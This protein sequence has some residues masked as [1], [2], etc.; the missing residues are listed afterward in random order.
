MKSRQIGVTTA[1]ISSS[2]KRAILMQHRHLISRVA[3]GLITFFAFVYPSLGLAATY[4]VDAATGND[5]LTSQQ[6]RDNPSA[7]LKTIKAALAFAFA[8]DTV[9]V[10]PGTYAEAVESKRDGAAGAL[11]TLQGTS[12]AVIQPPTKRNG[13]FVSHSYIAIKG[14]TVQ[15]AAT[16]LKLG[17][18]DGGSG[19]VAGLVI[20]NNTITNNTYGVKFTNAPAGEAAGNT[21]AQN[22]VDGLTFSNANN[23]NLHDNTVTR[24]GRFGFYIKGGTGHLLCNNTVTGNTRKDIQLTGQTI[25][26]GGGGGS[27]G[28]GGGFTFYVN[29]I[30]GDN[31]DATTS[32]K[33]ENGK[34]PNTPLKTINYALDRCVNPGDTV[35]LVAGTYSESVRTKRDGTANNPITITPKTPTDVVT[36]Q[37]PPSSPGIFVTNSYYIIDSLKITGGT[38]GV[39]VEPTATGV[40]TITGVTVRENEI[41]GSSI[42]MRFTNVSNIK[43]QA[44]VIHN[45]LANGIVYSGSAANIF[46]NLI[47]SNS[48]YGITLRAG[49]NHQITNN[50]V[51]N[52]VGG[53]RLGDSDT[54]PVFSTVLNNIVALNSSVGVKEPGGAN[55]AGKATLDYN[56]V[57]GN[58]TDYDLSHGAGGNTPGV[59]S[60]KADPVFV[61]AP[62]CANGH[63]FCLG[64]TQTGQGSDSPAIDKGSNTAESL[65]LGGS[66]AF[67]DM[68]P[69]A[70]QVD[71]GYHAP[72]KTTA[73]TLTITSATLTLGPTSQIFNVKA[74]LA[75]GPGSD[76]IQP[77]TQ[78]AKLTIG[79]Q[80]Y[81]LW[82]GGGSSGSVSGTLNPGVNGSVD[83]NITVNGLALQATVSLSTDI[84]I[85]VG[86][87]FGSKSII[88]K[89][90][91][92][93]P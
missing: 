90:T 22:T 75:P 38:F 2:Q 92:V 1:P 27:G 28:G 91:L 93:Y 17:P 24:N 9:S 10:Q 25:P 31:G 60:F 35:S 6:A 61:N 15:K 85:Q 41:S 23:A 73:G 72:L 77:S 74:N 55:Y 34:N 89:G 18:H 8:G 12:G 80:P 16:G 48:N 66:T 14:L 63:G 21:I 47:Y 58:S 65:S 84:G 7:P 83:V 57:F 51:A 5:S 37:P 26:C 52:N 45:C 71:L 49:S 81:Y 88:M 13:I 79:G 87:D 70:G 82:P 62:L 39:Q 29:P 42:G 68:S 67:V 86:D 46:N 30:T 4:Y 53:L 44:N 76:G 33:C 59:H 19:P 40:T 54:V 20:S 32:V 78:F 50:T 64:R 3:L 43:V 69:D 56:D 36:I 11:I